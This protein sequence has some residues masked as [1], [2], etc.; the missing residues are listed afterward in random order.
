VSDKEFPSGFKPAFEFLRERAVDAHL[1]GDG[2]RVL[3]LCCV[4]MEHLQ[5]SKSGKVAQH[6]SF[7]FV[8]WCFGLALNWALDDVLLRHIVDG[9]KKLPEDGDF[10]FDSGLLSFVACHLQDPINR[11][12]TEQLM[13]FPAEWIYK[14]CSAVEDI[15]ILNFAIEL[16]WTRDP[17]GDSWQKLAQSWAAA[18]P[19]ESQLALSLLQTADRLR[20]QTYLTRARWPEGDQ[21]SNPKASQHPMAEGFEQLLSCEW[22]KLDRLIKSLVPHVRVDDSSYPALFRLIHASRMERHIHL[23]ESQR[24]NVDDQVISLNRYR[25]STSRQPALVYES[26]RQQLFLDSSLRLSRAESG[27]TGDRLSCLR[28]SMLEELS[29]LRNWDLIAWRDSIRHQAD[30]SLDVARFKEIDFAKLGIVNSV[31]ALSVPD[32][33]KESRFRDA[34]ELMD[35]ARQ[36]D[37]EEIVGELLRTR[38]IEWPVVYRTFVHLSDAIPEAML[39]EIAKWSV[40]LETTTH[41]VSFLQH[42]WLKFWNDIIGYSGNA[43]S[44]VDDLAPALLR[45]SRLP[46]AWH[47]EQVESLLRKVLI[48]ARLPFAQEIFETLSTLPQCDSR[49]ESIRWSILFNASIRRPEFREVCIDWLS[50]H[51]GDDPVKKHHLKRTEQ[52]AVRRQLFFR[53]SDN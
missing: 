50:E 16:V 12:E 21:P 49:F 45:A 14:R 43:A 20:Y 22:E 8:R 41:R 51:A 37:R 4:A 46:I 17:F 52:D 42:T 38:P 47:D 44:L 5:S 23:P 29:A 6:V 48:H 28:L 24:G 2:L 25:A 53:V 19:S 15:A 7:D 34:V 39:P 33:K 32:E 18:A 11:H 10:K 31:R 13:N 30:A 3:Q 9:I 40:L 27:G 35:V 1:A 26:Y 36:Q